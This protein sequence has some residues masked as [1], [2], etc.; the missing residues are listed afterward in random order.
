MIF[1]SRTCWGEEMPFYSG[2]LSLLEDISL[3]LIPVLKKSMK[4][5]VFLYIHCEYIHKMQIAQTFLVVRG[6]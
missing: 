6:I 3:E 5:N 4:R 2:L 1:F